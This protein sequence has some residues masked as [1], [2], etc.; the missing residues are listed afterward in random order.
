MTD[1]PSIVFLIPLASRR[2]RSNWPAACE[3][4][5][6]TLRSIR[7]SESQN[8]RVVVAGSEELEPEEIEFN[9]RIHFLSMNHPFPSLANNRAAFRLDK[10]A[11]I[12]AAWR[13]A[14][15]NWQPKFVMKLDADDF[16]SSRLV[17]WLDNAGTEAG[18][19][20]RD[21]WFWRSRARYLIQHTEHLDRVCGSCLI[22]RSDL[23]D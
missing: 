20:I 5:Q 19:L 17:G 21:G 6:Q 11:K 4:L 15:A 16:I 10:L 1:K 7:N 23:A 9:S 8:Y 13:Y 18:Y 22:I 12:D 3:Y 2:M 14:K